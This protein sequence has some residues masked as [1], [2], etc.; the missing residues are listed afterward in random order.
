MMPKKSTS[1]IQNK[2]KKLGE[3]LG[4]IAVIEEQMHNHSSYAPIYD[5]VWYMDL[6]KYFDLDKL[7]P[8]FKNNTDLFNRLKR[9][10]YAG[11]EIEGASTSSKN[12]IGNFANLMS[13]PFLYRYVIVNNNEANG[14]NATY[15]RGI[16]LNSYMQDSFGFSNTFFLDLAQLDESIAGF[17]PVP[18]S[19]HPTTHNDMRRQ[20]YGGETKS[21]LLY[22]PIK[23]YISETGLSII[24]NYQP[25][26][27]K[28]KYELLRMCC[29]GDISD[30]AAFY[31]HNRYY[32]E[33]Y[34][35]EIKRSSSAKTGIYIPKL[36]LLLGF[37]APAGFT[38]WMRRLANTLRNDC[39]HYP[40]M[41]FLKNTDNDIFVPLIGIELEAS[42]NKHMNG[43]ICNMSKYS[44]C[45]VLLSNGNAEDRIE[46]L[47]KYLG[48]TNI[49]SICREELL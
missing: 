35:Y 16:K 31:L 13:G 11:F 3:Q 46:F 38:Q 43:G 12:Q 17:S 49:T 4:F 10:P 40:I 26:E 14:E 33:P 45:G 37:N 36:D 21:V 39:V 8:L 6:T 22:E 47:R 15:R 19:I 1:D 41:Y 24:Q 44:Y 27:L 28:I 34:D 42:K 20:T 7:M 32:N 2:I 48:I 25:E 18:G 9:L 23:N 5:A 29:H 30:E